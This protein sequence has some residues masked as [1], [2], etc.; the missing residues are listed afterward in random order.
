MPQEIKRIICVS[1]F[2]NALSILEL[3][4]SDIAD[5][6]K[7]VN[8]NK[9]IFKNSNIYSSS[10]QFVLKPGH[11]ALILSLPDKFKEFYD[12]LKGKKPLE[13]PVER[14]SESELTHE[15]IEKLESYLYNF[16]YNV[17]FGTDSVTDFGS[18]N[19]GQN[20]SCRV[21]CPFCEKKLIV[22]YVKHWILGNIERHFRIDI[23]KLVEK[24]S[25]KET[26]QS[27]LESETRSENDTTDGTCIEAIEE[28]IILNP[29]DIPSD[30]L[31]DI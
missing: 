10:E 2:D 19:K 27:E 25:E 29:D 6:E 8:E 17:K 31:D 16:N 22:N 18:D 5:I 13:K 24:D 30:I 20:I 11:R 15:L 14:K 21:K 26:Q 3:K 28:V 12:S 1:G 4:A 7:C 9:N 23:E